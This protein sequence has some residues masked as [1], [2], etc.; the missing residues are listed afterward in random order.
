ML[1][2]HANSFYRG[3]TVGFVMSHKHL[4]D[5]NGCLRVIEMDVVILLL[6]MI[7]FCV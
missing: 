1:S 4:T 3:S 5:F 2:Q 7:A 6:M